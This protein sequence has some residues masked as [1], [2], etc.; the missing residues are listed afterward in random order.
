[1]I[2]ACLREVACVATSEY[3]GREMGFKTCLR[4][5]LPGVWSGHEEEI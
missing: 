4:W 5:A 3:L 1:M 2:R